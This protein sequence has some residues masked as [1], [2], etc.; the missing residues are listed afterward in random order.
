MSEIFFLSVD[1]WLQP[2]PATDSFCMER[3]GEILA[4]ESVIQG[5]TVAFTSDEWL[6]RWNDHKTNSSTHRPAEGPR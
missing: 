1:D 6:Q 3:W 2:A 5:G 4:G